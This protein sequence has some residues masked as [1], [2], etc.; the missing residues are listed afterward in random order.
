MNL[1]RL[2]IERKKPIEKLKRY[3][4]KDLAINDI[5]TK[6]ADHLPPHYNAIS[7]TFLRPEITPCYTILFTRLLS[8]LQ[9]LK[10][11]CYWFFSFSLFK[12]WVDFFSLKSFIFLTLG[13]KP[14][15]R[16]KYWVK[17]RMQKL[18]YIITRES[19]RTIPIFGRY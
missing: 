3:F 11:F 8:H 5:T 12:I 7:K 2:V 9:V 19:T 4:L 18:R 10:P 15:L 13:A 17:Q 1:L 6:T 14:Y 16:V